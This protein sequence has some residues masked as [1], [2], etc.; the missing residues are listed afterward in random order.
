M[1]LNAAREAA[2]QAANA[3]QQ[4]A[5]AAQAARDA[6]TT[7]R[8]S[9]AAT[10]AAIDAATNALIRLESAI[11]NRRCPHCGQLVAVVARYPDTASLHRHSRESG[12][13]SAFPAIRHCR[14]LHRHSCESGNP[15]HSRRYA[16]AYLH[17]H[18]RESG[19]LR[20]P[21]IGRPGHSPETHWIPAFAGMTVRA[22]FCP[23][24]IRIVKKPA[25]TKVAARE[26]RQGRAFVP[27][28]SAQS[29]TP[30]PRK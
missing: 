20:D 1:R 11:A 8:A 30:A 15:A 29:R 5:N 14:Y 2:Q 22:S 25:P 26:W 4:A 10:I 3:A 12:K 28:Q 9:S 27:G 18:S 7:I 21:A 6:T 16:I 24:A 13:S 23:R 17:R 19:N